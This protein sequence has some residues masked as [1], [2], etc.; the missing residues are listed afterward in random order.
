VERS[1]GLLIPNILG[2]VFLAYAVRFAR[3]G[4][5]LGLLKV[6]ISFGT[7]VVIFAAGLSMTISPGKLGEV[8]KSVLIRELDGTPVARTAPAVV[9]ERATDAIGIVAWGLIGALSFGLAPWI[10]LVLLALTMLGVVALRSEK[11]P[12]RVQRLLSKLPLL[13]HLAPQIGAFHQ[14][15]NKLLA[16]KPLTAASLISFLA[17]GIDCLAVYLCTVGVGVEKPFLVIV[18]IYAVS[19]LAGNLSMLPSGIGVTEGSLVGLFKT[20]AGVS[21]GLSMAVTLLIRFATLWFAT[22]IGVI[23]LLLMPRHYAA[24]PEATATEARVEQ[25]T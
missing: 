12:L 21:G 10:F 17:W 5:Y 20:V 1:I 11:L 22:L 4:Y 14:S 8:L 18:F 9:A 6:R 2:L 24:P 15:S 13:N 16:L 19:L 7:G 25:K 3:W 23:G